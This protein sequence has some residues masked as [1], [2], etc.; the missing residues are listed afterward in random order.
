MKH[1]PGKPHELPGNR[2]SL[3]GNRQKAYQ[4]RHFSYRAEG[5][6]AIDQRSTDPSGRTR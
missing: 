2:Q 6:V 3:P 4:A 1:L 5:S